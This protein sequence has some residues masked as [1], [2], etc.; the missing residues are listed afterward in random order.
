MP[1]DEDPRM[2]VAPRHNPF[3]AVNSAIATGLYLTDVAFN[4][5]VEYGD[6]SREDAGPENTVVAMCV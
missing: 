2:A 3:F 1:R 5:A 6:F 4:A